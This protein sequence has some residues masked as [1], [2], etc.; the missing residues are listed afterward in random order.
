MQIVA[1]V[2]QVVKSQQERKYPYSLPAL[3]EN[4]YNLQV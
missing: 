4:L 2:Y 1:G 3:R